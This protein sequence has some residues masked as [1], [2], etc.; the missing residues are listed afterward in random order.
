[1]NFIL[2]KNDFSVDHL[3]FS[4]MKHNIII[5]GNFSKIFYSTPFFVLNNILIDFEIIPTEFRQLLC[6]KTTTTMPPSNIS[7]NYGN[8]YAIYFDLCENNIKI[9][10]KI[11]EIE[12]NILDYY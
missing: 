9:M 7:S 12:K 5:Y 8:K 11:I 3:H 4:E 6:M 1:M 10:Q 2:D